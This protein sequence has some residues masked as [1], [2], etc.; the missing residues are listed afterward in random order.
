VPTLA[1]VGFRAQS[2]HVHE[3]P[4][5][6]SRGGIR[7][8]RDALATRMGGHRSVSAGQN[9]RAKRDYID[10]MIARLVPRALLAL[11][12]SFSVAAFAVAPTDAA[13]DDVT[14][15]VKALPAPGAR[16]RTFLEIPSVLLDRLAIKLSTIQS[17]D[18]GLA[19]DISAKVPSMSQ[20]K[21]GRVGQVQTVCTPAG[22]SQGLIT[23]NDGTSYMTT[24]GDSTSARLTA[25]LDVTIGTHSLHGSV[26][27]APPARTLAH[28]CSGWTK[29]PR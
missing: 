7:Q 14:A 21:L 23:L 10:I 9:P 26:D 19:C 24:C 13:S 28:S 11:M 12:L 27:S 4:G 6:H 3:L 29:V 8:L 18:P 17:V 20:A 5:D 15:F 25:N 22:W 16:D 1:K 2:I